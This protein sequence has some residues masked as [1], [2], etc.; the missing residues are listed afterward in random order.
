[1]WK[2]NPNI[3]G[4]LADRE[5]SEKERKDLLKT[6]LMKN[7]ASRRQGEAANGER[8]LFT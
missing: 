2:V 7:F 8:D 3:K 1:M 5:R 4:L 6:T